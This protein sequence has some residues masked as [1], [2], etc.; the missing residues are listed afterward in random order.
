MGEWA[1]SL[2]EV[3]PRWVLG[4]EKPLY[5]HMTRSI[6][7]GWYFVLRV[8]CPSRQVGSCWAAPSG[9]PLLC[10]PQELVGDTSREALGEEDE[11][12]FQLE[13]M[14]GLVALSV[15]PGWGR[16]HRTQKG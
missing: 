10:L 4:T 3:G 13:G 16:V 11:E 14:W 2:G 5:Y 6:Q 12:D 9:N 8:T 15:V 7:S 1:W